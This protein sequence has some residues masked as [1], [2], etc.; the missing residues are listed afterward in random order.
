MIGSDIEFIAPYNS[1]NEKFDTTYSVEKAPQDYAGEQ[2]SARHYN[3]LEQRHDW[4]E[5]EI[6][7]MEELRRRQGSRT[8]RSNRPKAAGPRRRSLVKSEETLSSSEKV[9]RVMLDRE[10]GSGSEDSEPE[11]A[12]V[13]KKRKSGTKSRLSNRKKSET[14]ELPIK[15]EDIVEPKRKKGSLK[16]LKGTSADGS[17]RGPKTSTP[18]NSPDGG[19]IPVKES[20]MNLQRSPL[21]APVVDKRR[22]S[23]TKVLDPPTKMTAGARRLSMKDQRPRK[24]ASK[25]QEIK[26]A[27]GQST[28]KEGSTKVKDRMP[29]SAERRMSGS[30]KGKAS[31]IGKV[32]YVREVDEA[33]RSV[34]SHKKLKEVYEDDSERQKLDQYS[35][36]ASPKSTRRKSVPRQII[37]EEKQSDERIKKD[38][39]GSEEDQLSNEKKD[40]GVKVERKKSR[41]KTKLARRQVKLLTVTNCIVVFSFVVVKLPVLI[42]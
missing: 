37:K 2:S 26:T 30:N 38:K 6:E 22:S 31:D 39:I 20:R 40:E 12:M 35:K 42:P 24:L 18:K 3:Y 28:E 14:E 5:Q 21:K 36:E 17:L 25:E 16:E 8:S 29:D 34:V 41:S 7:E 9:D 1:P 10:E 15:E 4:D 19:L 27:M 32:P 13:L 33:G 23:K 11:K